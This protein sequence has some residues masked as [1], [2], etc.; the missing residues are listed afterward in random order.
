LDN[1]LFFGGSVAAAVVAGVLALFAPCCISVML[2][3]YFAG[4]F[5]NRGLLIAMTFLFAAGVAT[6][7]LPLAMGAAALRQLIT[8][9]H[10]P[11]YIAA[12][13]LMIA[14]AVYTFLG[15]QLHLPSPGRSPTGRV[16][17]AS[18]YSLGLFSGM[19][20][21][22][23]AP[24][25]AGVI[26]LA[27]V[28]SSFALALGLGLAYVFGMVAPLFIVAL[29]WERFDWRSSGL[30]RPRSI[31]WKLIGVTRTMSL[32]SLASVVLLAIM[33][34]ATVVVGLKGESMDLS[35]WQA[36]FAVQLQRLGQL[37]TQVL[38]VVPGWTVG[39]VLALLLA[40]LA[41]RAVNELG[42]TSQ[43][44]ASV[45]GDEEEQDLESEDQERSLERQR[46]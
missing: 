30:F 20:T 12:G 45:E 2:P 44:N 7:I 5:Q 16:G 15:G 6:I 38:S 4:S 11:I 25:L 43:R 33:G 41:W 35:G 32:A 23:C 37:G 22:C 3:A 10:T 34:V 24:V 17:P 26:A 8:V 42:W 36:N 27:G 40:V 14:L 19:A 28:A 21:S 29:L 31:T 9:G 13:L 39:V 18:V 46:P 1:G